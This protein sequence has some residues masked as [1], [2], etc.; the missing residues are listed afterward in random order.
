MVDFSQLELM[1]RYIV[2]HLLNVPE[3][4]GNIILAPYDF[5]SLCRVTSGLSRGKTHRGRSWYRKP[6]AVERF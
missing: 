5:S 2:M 6:R 1:M 4:Q 3:E